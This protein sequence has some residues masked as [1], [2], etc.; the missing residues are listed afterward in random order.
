MNVYFNVYLICDTI[1]NY[2]TTMKSE[3]LR[4]AVIIACNVQVLVY[5][6]FLVVDYLSNISTH[7]IGFLNTC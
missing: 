5:T 7:V 4:S 6:C 3:G 2:F 1:I